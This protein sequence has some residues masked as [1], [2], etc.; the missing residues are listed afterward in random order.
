[1]TPATSSLLRALR[2]VRWRSHAAPTAPAAAVLLACALAWL[3]PGCTTTQGPDLA[4]VVP[5]L[6]E[7][8]GAPL[9][10]DQPWDTPST[11]WDGRSPLTAQA[12]LTCALQNNRALRRALAE[13]DRRRAFYRDSQLPPNPMIDVAAGVPLDMG[14]TPILAMLSAQIDW[15]WKREAIVGQ[16]DAALR[17]GLFQAAAQTVTTAVEAR[18]A[19][20]NAASAREVL[21]LSQA[22]VTVATR[23]LDATRA[24]FDAGEATAAAVNDARMNQAEA[25]NRAMEAHQE[26]EVAKLRL[27]RVMGRPALETDWQIVA[28]STTEAVQ[29]CGLVFT[30][31]PQDG[32]DLATLVRARRLDLVA[33]EARVEGVQQR[34]T[35]IKAGQWP[36]ITLQ[37]GYERDMNG[38]DAAM[39]GA[40]ITLPIFNQGQHRVQAAEAELE[41]A[42]IEADALWQQALLR[43]RQAL[44]DLGVAEHHA[45]QLRDVTLAAFHA[46]KRLLQ[47]G[48]D[49]GEVS[50]LRLWQSEHQE[51]HIRIQLARAQRDGALAA[52]GFERALAGAATP[53]GTWMDGEG[54]GGNTR[55]GMNDGAPRPGMIESVLLEGMQ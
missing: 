15:L 6:E 33:A 22:D 24:A 44:G 1:M 30:E 29:E 14:V 42:R 26:L 51:N 49:A 7:R 47:S 40:A 10:S 52:L 4:Q 39:F 9:P 41:I 18:A 12:T 27:L 11:A 31:P 50:P 35:W 55:M 25:S 8:L 5:D 13:I 32:E 3:L 28:A 43:V 46:N 36:A 16:A 45:T 37:G 48:V 20:V 34:L 23:V 38:D 54:M 2:R 19:Y 53:S 21:A 17:E